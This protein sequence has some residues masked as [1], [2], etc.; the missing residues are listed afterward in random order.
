MPE[1]GRNLT[2][3]D[4]IMTT[5][6]SKGPSLGDHVVKPVFVAP[7]NRIFAV[8]SPQSTLETQF[9]DNIAPLAAYELFPYLDA[10]S[11]YFVLSG[12]S[13]A[14][15]VTSGAAAAVLG[16]NPSMT[17][18]QVKARLMLTASK[19]FPE[20]TVIATTDPSIMRTRRLPSSTISLPSGPVTSMFMPR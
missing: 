9:P 10:N 2:R 17:P 3:G 19:N 14:A 1:H 18:D 15:A 13:M 6:S 4:D 7:G 8:R 5:Y 20:S 12:T 16:N 11:K